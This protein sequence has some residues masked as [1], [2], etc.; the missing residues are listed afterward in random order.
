MPRPVEALP[1][2]SRSTSSTFQPIAA[3]AVARLIAV[4]VL[5]TPP[6][7]LAIATRI[8]G[9]TSPSLFR[10]HVAEHQ[11]GRVRISAARFA[12]GITLPASLGFGQFRFGVSALGKRP[13]RPGMRQ[14]ESHAQ[15][16]AERR[17]RSRGDYVILA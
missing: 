9:S 4:V 11:D 2:G 13:N 7:W 14:M 6:F 5:P 10:L 15:Q 3:S 12:S 17:D 16:S 1:C 8:I